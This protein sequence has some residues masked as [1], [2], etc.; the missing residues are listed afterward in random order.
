MKIYTKYRCFT[1]VELIVVMLVSSLVVAAVW[2]GYVFIKQKTVQITKK[3][4]Q[5]TALI[6]LDKTIKHDFEIADLIFSNHNN[7]VCHNL[8][9]E[10]SYYFNKNNIIRISEGHADTLK[11]EVVDRSMSYVDKNNGINEIPLK[12]LDLTIK[13]MEKEYTFIYKK[14]YDSAVLIN[15]ELELK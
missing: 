14:K 1:V 9:K 12:E 10:I 3:S 6:F 15:R 2:R 5:Y 8:S 7:V 11:Y 4:D 13:L